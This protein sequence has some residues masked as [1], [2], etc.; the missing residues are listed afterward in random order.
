MRVYLL[1]DHDEHGSENMVGTAD[2]TKLESMLLNHW[3]NGGEIQVDWLRAALAENAPG[4][5]SHPG[6]WGGPQLHV[7]DLT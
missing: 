5:W 6:G 2:P 4:K 7:V 3:G 1:S